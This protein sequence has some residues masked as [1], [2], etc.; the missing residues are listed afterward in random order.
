MPEERE[1]ARWAKIIA[2]AYAADTRPPL[3]EHRLDQLAGELADALG[4]AAAELPRERWA[5]CV[6]PVLDRWEL[7]IGLV[8][9]RLR[10]VDVAAGTA[11][12]APRS[13]ADHPLRPFGGQ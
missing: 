7:A 13:E 6:N 9:P 11:V 5:D 4:A 2:A 10:D 1:A 12:M 8:G 3:P